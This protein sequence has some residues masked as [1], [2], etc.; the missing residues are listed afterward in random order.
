MS[1]KG[2]KMKNDEIEELKILIPSED[3][4]NYALETGWSFTDRE[5]AALLIYSSLP[6]KEQYSHLQTLQRNTTD[7][8]LQ[9]QI[10]GYLKR[11]ECKFQAFK[12]NNDKAYI[13]ILKVKD[14]DISYSE[15]MPAEYF[16][17]LN[18]AYE[19]GKETDLPFM[20]EKYLV[21]TRAHINQ[22]DTVTA[23][24]EFDKDGKAVY[25]CSGI[26]NEEETEDFYE[27]FEVPN[28]FEKGDIVRLVG[29]E[30]YGIVA[31]SQETWKEGIAKYKSDEWQHKHRDFSD[32]QIKVEFLGEDGTFGHEH[33]NPLYLERYRPEEDWNKS[34]PMDKLLLQA[35]YVHRGKGSLEDLYAFTMEYRNFKEG[36]AR[37]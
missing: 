6:L 30:M 10:A 18:L 24:L 1:R 8:R 14:E 27:F 35:S 29:T 15:I 36:E 23:S 11:E 7:Q 34:S 21:E 19:C 26:S 9:E 20:I 31:T 37:E 25:L 17:E 13:Y 16:F 32:I 28:P 5:K 2:S 3:V 33:I 12:E 4:R 22:R